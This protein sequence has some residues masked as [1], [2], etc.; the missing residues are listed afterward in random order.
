MALLMTGFSSFTPGCRCVIDAA[1]DEEI[2]TADE[3]ECDDVDPDVLLELFEKQLDSTV[4]T[5]STGELG[6]FTH[7]L[8]LAEIC[9]HMEP[10]LNEYDVQ[11][12]RTDLSAP[13]GVTLRIQRDGMTFGAKVVALNMDALIGEWNRLHP[14]NAVNVGDHLMMI[15][16]MPVRVVNDMH[17]MLYEARDIHLRFAR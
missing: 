15:N 9:E 8:S 14:E 12:Q 4:E 16:G 10:N 7:S 2:D 5:L 17:R 3:E 1:G 6:I 13:L 11:V